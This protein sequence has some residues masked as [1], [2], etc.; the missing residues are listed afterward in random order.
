VKI[1]LVGTGRMGTAVTALAQ[2]RGHEIA[3]TFSGSQPL[4]TEGS[5]A[6]LHGADVVI[7]FSL[8]SVVTNHLQAYCRWRQPAVVGTTGWDGAIETVKGWVR[9]HDASLLYAPNF[10]LG[11]QLML[12][13]IRGLAPLLDALPEYDVAI[14]ES[15]HTGKVDRPSGTALLI[16][17]ALVQRLERKTALGPASGPVDPKTL[18]IASIRVGDVFGEHSAIIDSFFDKITITHVAKNRKGFALGAVKAAEW[19][20]GRTGFFTLEDIL[21]DWLK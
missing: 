5:V 17:Q 4:D 21:A 6:I 7:D 12:R 3:A 18:E 14:S 13:A 15:H 2:A 19:L 1:A 8:P 9:E 10:S 16:G 20:P 11:V